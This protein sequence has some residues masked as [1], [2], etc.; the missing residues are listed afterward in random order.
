MLNIY[1]CRDNALAAVTVTDQQ[2]RQPIPGVV[3]LEHHR[4]E[5]HYALKFVLVLQP[6]VSFVE[7]STSDLE[8]INDSLIG[9]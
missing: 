7:E 6:Q 1:F 5:V 4:A 2:T 8:A 3:E 9:V